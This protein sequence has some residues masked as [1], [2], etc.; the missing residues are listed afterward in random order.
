MTLNLSQFILN[1]KPLGSG[2]F[3]SVY[4]AKRIADERVVCIKFIKLEGGSSIKATVKESEMLSSLKNNH[5][6]EYY[7]SFVEHDVLCIVM[8]YA[9]HG[10]LQD[11][12]SV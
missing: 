4:L 1:D 5:I 8:E 6:I 7:G 12:I 10:S 11:V 3:G 9:Q 2:A